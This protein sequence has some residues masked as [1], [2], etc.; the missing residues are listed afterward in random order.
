M[1]VLWDNV[2]STEI[3][4]RI[5]RR[6]RA[7]PDYRYFS[8]GG[9][10]IYH[11]HDAW[12][13]PDGKGPPSRTDLNTV[14]LRQMAEV[15]RP[16]DGQPS[17]DVILVGNAGMIYEDPKVAEELL[18]AVRSGAVLA[19]CESYYPKKGSALADVWPTQPDTQA[20][21][22]T[23]GAKRSDL[24]DPLL[25]GVPLR[26]MTG[27]EYAAIP[28]PTE[29]TQVLSTGHCGAALLR[30]SGKGAIIFIPTK[31]ISEVH[32]AK[33]RVGRRYD[34]DEI[35]LRFWDHLL[36]EVAR[37]DVAFPAWTDLQLGVEQAEHDTTYALAA[38]LVNR[39]AAPE[40][41]VSVHVLSPQG[42]LV[43]SREES[44]NLPPGKEQAY[45]VRYPRR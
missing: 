32:D 22:M 45:P 24:H 28:Q 5:A 23:R 9:D 7:T 21:W 30:R 4:Q 41:S 43:F 40:L 16:R 1:L 13:E 37:G 2:D 17:Y 10:D 27:H 11:V 31:V 34:H 26:L 19:A 36:Y 38:T 3:P 44:V 18:N 42:N 20:T 33:E 14:T 8:R 12:I 39:S 25:A 15:L 35:W 29:G 6:L